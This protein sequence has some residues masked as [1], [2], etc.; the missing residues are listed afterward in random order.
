MKASSAFAI[1]PEGGVYGIEI[2]QPLARSWSVGDR[3]G[4]TIAFQ[5]V[6]KEVT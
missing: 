1:W 6:K 3:I 4:T 5:I 2:D